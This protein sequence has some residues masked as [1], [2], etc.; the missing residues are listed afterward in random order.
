MKF[1]TY[2]QI[3]N[4]GDVA[5]KK[6][7]FFFWT[8]HECMSDRENKVKQK[9]VDL[10]DKLEAEAEKLDELRRDKEQIL[11]TI[12]K[13]GDRQKGRGPYETRKLSYF[14]PGRVPEP[15]SNVWKDVMQWLFTNVRSMASSFTDGIAGVRVYNDDTEYESGSYEVL[16]T[17]ETPIRPQSRNNQKNQKNQQNNQR[18]NQ[19]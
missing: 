13:A 8:T 14:N 1:T 18:N 2:W 15:S 12:D 4:G 7:R 11:R 9:I 17:V 16:G 6:R 10:Y 19:Q 5:L 3:L